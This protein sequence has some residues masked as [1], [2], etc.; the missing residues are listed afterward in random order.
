MDVIQWTTTTHIQQENTPDKVE[1]KSHVESPNK[2]SGT[3]SLID[4]DINLIPATRQYAF[5]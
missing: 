3:I 4:G 2:S 1:P 5:G